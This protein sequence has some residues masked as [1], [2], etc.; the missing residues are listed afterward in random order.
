[1][2]SRTAGSAGSRGPT[3][4]QPSAG[5][6]GAAFS[7]TGSGA[8]A[9]RRD[10]YASNVTGPAAAAAVVGALRVPPAGTTR[11]KASAVRSSDI[12]SEGRA[13]HD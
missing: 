4:Y 7:S 11:I 1:V 6:A 3:R 13:G 8:A 12:D 10:R 5:T 2:A 9:A